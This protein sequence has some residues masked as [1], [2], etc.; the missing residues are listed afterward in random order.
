M[1]LECGT[2]ECNATAINQI[3]WPGKPP[4]PTCEFC[5]KRAR[6]IAQA[7]GFYLHV[8]KLANEEE[9]RNIGAT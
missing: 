2:N 7:M 8:S 9:S 3:Y 5:T 4:M 6:N 1:S